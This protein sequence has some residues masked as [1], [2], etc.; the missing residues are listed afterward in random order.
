[1]RDSSLSP[2]AEDSR[3]EGI[4]RRS[5]LGAVLGGA[6]AVVGSMAVLAGGF[7]ANAF[8]RRKERPW[9]RV[10]PAEDL[11]PETFGKHVVT[12]EQQHGWVRERRPLVLYIQDL[13]PEDPIALL[14]R[15]THLGCS[16]NWDAQGER[17]RCPCHG[18]VYDPQGKVLEGPPPRPLT[19]LEVKIDEDEVC[20]VRFPG[21][22]GQA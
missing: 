3:T 18:G 21:S 6:A 10:G 11:N 9:I 20:F 14:S 2:P 17:F 1:M 8:G 12:V 22:E 13:Y 19:R 16:V 5:A 4:S 15:C 7:V